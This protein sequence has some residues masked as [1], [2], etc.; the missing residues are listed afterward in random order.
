MKF[1]R[2]IFRNSGIFRKSGMSDQPKKDQC[3]ICVKY[4]R[5]NPEEKERLEASQ[6]TPINNNKK[7]M[8][9]KLAYKTR[10]KEDKSLLVFN[11]D[12]EAVLYTR[13]IKSAPYITCES[14]AHTT[15]LP[16]I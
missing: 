14:C 12:L 5:S 2:L 10:G 11:F 3:K 7:V 15:Q 4:I 16:L 9:L 1:Q 13:A 8:E 6:E